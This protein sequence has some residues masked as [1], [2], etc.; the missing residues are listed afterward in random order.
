LG[1]REGVETSWNDYAT[2]NMSDA[3]AFIGRRDVTDSVHWQAVREGV[4]DYEYLAMV[5]DAAA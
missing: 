3:P 2:T 5:R 4:E 1:I